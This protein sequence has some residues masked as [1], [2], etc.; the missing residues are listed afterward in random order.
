MLDIYGKIKEQV[1]IETKRQSKELRN[2][3]G[4]K[5][6]F[7]TARNLTTSSLNLSIA[8]EEGVS[9]IEF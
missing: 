3:S 7:T 4:S 2:L 1:K 8:N 5:V 6:S 9:D